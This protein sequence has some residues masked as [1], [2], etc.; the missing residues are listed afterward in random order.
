MAA[1]ITWPI[2]RTCLVAASVA[3]VLS[4][5][6]AHAQSV[7][8]EQR[9][10][11]GLVS[12]KSYS[13]PYTDVTVNVT[14]TG[15][16]GQ[17]FN[18]YG[19]WDG[20]GNFK[21]RAAFPTAG[22]WTWSTTASDPTDTGLH[23]RSGQVNV[24]AYS[25]SNP[26]YQRGMLKV[27]DN[28]RYLTY[29]D[30]TPFNWLGDTAWN[31]SWKSS[32][33]EWREYI[34]HRAAQGFNVVQ[35]HATRSKE[36]FTNTNQDG[37]RPFDSAAQAPTPA[38]WR[39]LE[40]K[41]EYANQKGLVVMLVGVGY[42]QTNYYTD[43]TTQEPFARFI[44]GRL[45]GNHVIFS[46][47]MDQEY[48]PVNDSVGQWIDEATDRHLV[49]QHVSTS[50]AAAEGFHDKSYLDFDGMQS[51][52]NAGNLTN[53][54]NR[55]R[56]WALQLYNNPLTKPVINT[57]AMYDGRGDDSG[58]N[59][60]EKDARKLG[61]ITRLS[62]AAGYTYGAGMTSGTVPGAQEGIWG[63]STNSDNT[64]PNDHWRV[65]M[66]WDSSHQV[67]LMKAFFDEIEWWELEPAHELILN[68]GTGVNAMVLALSAA[69]DLGVAYLPDNASILIDMTGFSSAVHAMWFHPVNGTLVALP[70]AIANTGAYSFARPAGWEDAVLTL[71]AV[72]EPAS[73]A[74]L[75]A[76]GAAVLRRRG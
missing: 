35:V 45:H 26:L 67:A 5:A 64:A 21:V 25:G 16:G 55:A 12:S 48:M 51:G 13:N 20:G 46:P 32:D 62:G 59:W 33:A 42:P 3:A 76:C 53:A 38:Y 14:F 60:R 7:E 52:H 11:Q 47:S 70:D 63:W 9:W 18:S 58:G 30:G 72:P 68:Q 50:I 54:Y 66:D 49:T 75:L 1:S 17:T 19:F 40:E 29:G 39:D 61:W 24:T 44:A 8:Q 2:G 41:I 56:E 27:S 34:D 4:T 37:N 36:N 23:N 22:L 10:E 65:A 71:V 31:S 74:V 69:G 57:E 43:Y 73:L 28:Q 15:P 6:A